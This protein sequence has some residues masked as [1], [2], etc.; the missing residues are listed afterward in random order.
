M[1]STERSVLELLLTREFPGRDELLVQ[2][3]TVQT[4]GPSCDCGCPSFG[5]VA[6]RFLPPAPVT[7]R[8][9]TDAH[10]TDPGGNEIGVLLFVDDGYL[11][12]V[13]VFDY[14]DGNYAGLP[15]ASALKLSQW[16]EWVVD[17]DGT[18]GRI[19]LNP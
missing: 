13:D 10:G 5:L 1:N 12:D 7:T 16:S 17:D 3:E 6:D 11:S 15:D 19:L 2:A 14:G 8:M 18:R 4:D 9:P